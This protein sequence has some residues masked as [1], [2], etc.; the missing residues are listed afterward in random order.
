MNAGGSPH[1]E[2]LLYGASVTVALEVRQKRFEFGAQCSQLAYQLF[3]EITG[4]TG[5]P[6]GEYGERGS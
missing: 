2:A 3:T 5:C 1:P 4:N 6:S